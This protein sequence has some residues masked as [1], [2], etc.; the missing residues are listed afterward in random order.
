VEPQVDDCDIT[1]RQLCVGDRVEVDERFT[2]GNSFFEAACAIGRTSDP[3]ARN[4]TTIAG[5]ALPHARALPSMNHLTTTP[6][7]R[8]NLLAKQ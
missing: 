1:R 7:L 3:A 5:A 6:P 4:T 2:S 8:Y